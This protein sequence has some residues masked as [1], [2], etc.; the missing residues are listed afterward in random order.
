MKTKLIPELKMISLGGIFLGLA[1]FS[2]LKAETVLDEKFEKPISSE[3]W[4][5]HPQD[6]ASTSEGELTITA[7]GSE[8]A[9]AVSLVRL[10]H[11]SDTFNFTANKVEIKISDLSFKGTATEPGLEVFILA[12]T[13]DNA[14]DEKAT[15]KLRLR[16][17]SSGSVLVNTQNNGDSMPTR[18]LEDHAVLPIQSLTL[19]LSPSGIHLLFVDGSGQHERNVPLDSWQIQWKDSHPYFRLQAQRR[20]G[21]GSAQVALHG[22]IV[23]STSATA[24]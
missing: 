18:L 1:N 20:P 14:E 15:S 24:Q 11:P 8:S 22:L 10:A 9:Y 2:T 3:Q 13:S 23:N 7:E 12:L 5:V 21:T 16:V 17:D 6:A 19:T 4:K